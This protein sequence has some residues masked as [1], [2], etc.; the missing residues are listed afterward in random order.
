MLGRNCPNCARRLPYAGRRC[1]HCQWTVRW[2]DAAGDAVAL[3]RRGWVWGVTLTAAVLLAVNFAY[4]NAA[5]LAD[6]YAAF[7]AQHLSE[8][9]SSLAPTDSETGAFFYCARQV[10]RRMQGDFSVET[11]S[12][13]EGEKERLGDG[14]Y[15]IRSSVEEARLTGKS[16]RHQFTCTVRLHRGR[17]V[18]ED[19]KLKEYTAIGSGLARP[20]PL[21]GPARFYDSTP[22]ASPSAL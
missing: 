6:W 11:F 8:S 17:W 13:A 3:W 1:V 15:R 2:R 18:L 20:A 10:A 16:V 19:L 5:A 12:Q 14:R 7:A 21:P 4:R 9:A 22:P